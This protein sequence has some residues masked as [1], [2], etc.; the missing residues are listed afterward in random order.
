MPRVSRIS[1]TLPRELRECRTLT[2]VSFA[3]APRGGREG[4]V[5]HDELGAGLVGAGQRAVHRRCCGEERPERDTLGGGDGFGHLALHPGDG[6]ALE[7]TGGADRQ[8]V[9]QDD[10]DVVDQPR[11][12][13]VDLVAG[14]EQA[15][16]LAAVVRAE[17][18]GRAED[19]LAVKVG[20]RLKTAGAQV[21][22]A[23]VALGVRPG[24]QPAPDVLRRD[25]QRVV[26]RLGALLIGPVVPGVAALVGEADQ[27][28]GVQPLGRFLRHGVLLS[29]W[30]CTTTVPQW[31]NYAPGGVGGIF[32]RESG[33]LCPSSAESPGR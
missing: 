28:A 1:W 15:Q 24:E 18:A 29:L 4:A 32:A 12:E 8:A 22:G 6:P 10:A 30:G 27:R 11:A 33:R 20:D 5:A 31:S 13:R 9:V 17:R 14:F 23:D 26:V 2:R 16:D 19:R 25:R 3:S 7:Q 21:G